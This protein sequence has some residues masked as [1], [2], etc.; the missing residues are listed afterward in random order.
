MPD[1]ISKISH[2]ITHIIHNFKYLIFKEMLTFNTFIEISKPTYKHTKNPLNIFWNIFN[3]WHLTWKNKVRHRENLI[4]KEFRP[5]TCF[6]GHFL[7]KSKKMMFFGLNSLNIEISS[8]KIN[9][10]LNMQNFQ[11]LLFSKL[12]SPTKFIFSLSLVKK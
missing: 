11:Q 9:L 4:I 12:F 10:L 6:W 2:F 7:S 3:I 5:K 1:K 8:M